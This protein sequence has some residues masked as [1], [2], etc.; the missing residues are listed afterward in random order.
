MS[1]QLI[2]KKE[3]KMKP[4]LLLSI[5]TLFIVSFSMPFAVRA[6]VVPWNTE[7]YEVYTWAGAY[8]GP[9]FSDEDTGPPLPISAYSE[10]YY[11]DYGYLNFATAAAE[12]TD[13]TMSVSLDRRS[14]GLNYANTSFSGN[15]TAVN[16]Y[17]IF[18][19]DFSHYLGEAI[20]YRHF[21]Y[22][23]IKDLTT[24]TTLHLSDNYAGSD[25]L[26][27]PT[28]VGNEIDVYFR[29]GT[30]MTNR[31]KYSDTLTY[32]MSSSAVVPEPVS[33]ILFITGGS[34][35]AGRRYLRKKRS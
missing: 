23:D 29:F 28:T 4:K 21:L 6:D 22:I 32:S 24:S 19:Y 13:T 25:V 11:D 27:I 2:F 33:S 10:D 15:Y 9:G 12:I 31:Y 34:L 8:G 14:D 17:F 18:S 26:Y 20:P 7:V 16:S 3:V 1:N 30:G 5:L 35:L